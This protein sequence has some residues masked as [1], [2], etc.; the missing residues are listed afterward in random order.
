MG[1]Q[2][3]TEEDERLF[4]RAIRE[5]TAEFFGSRAAVRVVEPEG[6]AVA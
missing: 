6:D 2:S 1:G 4:R 5:V 3:W